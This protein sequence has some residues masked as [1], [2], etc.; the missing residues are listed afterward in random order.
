M[1]EQNKRS[2]LLFFKRLKNK[3]LI[4]KS[5][6]SNQTIEQEKRD[7]ILLEDQKKQKIK[8]ESF[9]RLSMLI[10]LFLSGILLT[11]YFISPL[12]KVGQLSV[13]GTQEV[14][15]QEIIDKSDI[16]S[17][18]PLWKT[19]FRKKEISQKTVEAIPQ[20]KEMSLSLKGMNNLD[21]EV[22]E[23]STAAYLSSGDQYR[24]IL[25]N[26]VIL[27]EK[28]S[29]IRGGYPILLQ[30]KEG[31]VLQRFLKEYDTL[32]E[33][34]QKSIS[35]IHYDPSETDSYLIRL[36]MNDGNQ[37]V[38]SIPTFSERMV[39]YPTM[40]AETGEEKGEFN[41]EAGAYFVPF[42]KAEETKEESEE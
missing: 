4:Q 13:H 42:E 35:E 27:T 8:K 7:D 30:F 17:G 16:H 24:K 25:E 15:V 19:Y 28:E 36:Y 33:S 18:D 38:A 5:P 14:I 9:I 22:Q 32:D 26:G 12:S 21:F 29:I 20:V 41:L 39:Y 6:S 31:K 40:K 34:L 3:G 37:I 11:V 2:S 23:Y 10:L 1:T